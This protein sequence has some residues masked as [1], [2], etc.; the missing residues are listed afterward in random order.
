MSSVATAPAPAEHAYSER[1]ASGC[2]S[3]TRRSRPGA[4]VRLAK[5]TSNLFRARA[6]AAGPGLDVAAFD[7]VLSVD[8]WPR[9]ADV[10]GMTTYEHLVDATLAHGLM[11][12]VV[13]QLKTI[14]LGGA[15]TG[16]GIESAS[17][18][19]GCP[20]ESVLELEV[21]DGRRA[22]SSSPAPTTSTATSTTGSRTPTARSAT[23]CG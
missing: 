7:G 5:R 20:H 3:S 13:P 9:T 2:A 17:F 19:N 11:P 22:R 14:T 1:V 10:Q 8:P 12:L 16:L 4:P 18:R 6:G 21:H 15:V 23:R